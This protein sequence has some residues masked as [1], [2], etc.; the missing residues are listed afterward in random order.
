MAGWLWSSQQG[1]EGDGGK[2]T[3]HHCEQADKEDG[4]QDRL[5]QVFPGPNFG[6]SRIVIRRGHV[7]LPFAGWAAG[8]IG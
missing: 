1:E 6:L 7:M 2:A 8:R 3:H 4:A 5:V